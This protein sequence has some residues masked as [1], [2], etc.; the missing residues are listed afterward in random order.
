[1]DST[2]ATTELAAE[3]LGVIGEIDRVDAADVTQ[4][5]DILAAVV[6]EREAWSTYRRLSVEIQLLRDTQARV[7]RTVADAETATATARGRASVNALR[8][9][10]ALTQAGSL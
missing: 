1:M 5:A 3:I 7:R 9:A 10:Y 8:L 6:A 2:L 4:A